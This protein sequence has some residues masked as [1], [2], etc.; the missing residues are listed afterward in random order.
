MLYAKIL[1]SLGVRRGKTRKKQET[2]AP[3]VKVNSI[4]FYTRKVLVVIIHYLSRLSSRLRK[5]LT[6]KLVRKNKYDY[7][8]KILIKY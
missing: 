4:F 8:N 2:W 1:I 5:F 3:H 6:I 7:Y